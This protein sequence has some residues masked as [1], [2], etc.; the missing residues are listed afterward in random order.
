MAILLNKKSYKYLLVQ[1]Y[2]LVNINGYLSYVSQEFLSTVFTK[3]KNLFFLPKWSI[4]SQVL[5]MR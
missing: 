1:S 2:M 3:L 5:E 4:L